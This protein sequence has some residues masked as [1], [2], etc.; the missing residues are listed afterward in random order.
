[1]AAISQTTV[2][3]AF[4]LMKT[5]ISDEIS[6]EYVP[7]GL[8]DNMATL[9]QTMEQVTDKPLPEVVLV[10]FTDAYMHHTAPVSY[11]NGI[12]WDYETGRQIIIIFSS[13]FNLRV[14]PFSD[15]YNARSSHKAVLLWYRHRPRDQRGVG[16][17]INVTGDD[18]WLRHWLSTKLGCLQCISR[19]DTS[20]SCTKPSAYIVGLVQDCGISIANTLE[21]NHSLAISHQH[22][23]GIVLV[24]IY[25]AGNL[26]CPFSICIYMVSAMRKKS[27]ISIPQ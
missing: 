11:T 7:Y 19:E 8:I 12:V 10:C 27:Y 2:S 14:F 21:I 26:Q 25:G 23:E 6:L 13:E 9:V 17:V 22:H 18:L 3:S 4:S 5:W 20:M 16:V 1:M 15:E 24:E